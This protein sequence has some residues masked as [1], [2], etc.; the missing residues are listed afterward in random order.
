MRNNYDLSENGE[1]RKIYY[2]E[3]ELFNIDRVEQITTHVRRTGRS[4]VPVARVR[5]V[6]LEFSL[7]NG[8]FADLVAQGKNMIGSRR[9][10]HGGRVRK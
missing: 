1:E 2:V 5:D 6:Q 3:N 7:K 4:D 10:K 9:E 8:V